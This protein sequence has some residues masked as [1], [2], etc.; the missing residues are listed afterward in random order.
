MLA[1]VLILVFLVWVVVPLF[2]RA[3]ITE[4]GTEP[5]ASVPAAPVLLATGVDEY[6]VMSWGLFGDGTL[7]VWRFDTGELVETLRP[8]GGEELTAL[9]VANSDGRYAVGFAD[10]KVR[11]AHFTFSSAFATAAELGEVAQRLDARGRALV[12]RTVVERT[13]EGEFRVQELRPVIGEP[14]E[15]GATNAITS[16]DASTANGVTRVLVCERG[17]RFHLAT[18]EKRENPFTGETISSASSIALPWTGRSDGAEPRNVLVSGVGDRLFVVWRDG[19]ARRYDARDVDRITLAEELDFVDGAGELTSLSFLIGRTTI[20]VGDS[21]GRLRAWFGV[22]PASATAVDGV[23][24]VLAHELVD[25]GGAR[26]TSVASSSRGRAIVAGFADGAVRVY[27]VT[28]QKELFT[29]RLDPPTPVVAVVFAPKDDGFAA[30]TNERSSRWTADLGHPEATVPALFGRVWYEGYEHPEHVWQS[31]SGTDDFEPKLGL[32]PLVFGTL[33]ATLYSLLFG[34]PLALLAA[35]YT[36]EFLDKRLKVPLKSFVELMASLPSVVLGFIAAIILAPFV[37][38][39]VPSV[40]A[41]FLTI[42]LSLLLG[43][44]LWQLLPPQLYVRWAGAPRFAAMFV[45]LPV[46]VLMAVVAGPAFER[47]F[48]GGDLLGWLDGQHGNG[49]GGWMLLLLPACALVFAFGSARLL[50]PFLRRASLTWSRGRA[51]SFDLARF[52]LS[53]VGV[54]ALAW[55]GALA[56]DGV[57]LDSRGGVLDTYE[58]R[59]ALIVGFIMGFAIIPIIYT[60][61]EDALSSVPSHLRLASLGAGATPWQTAVRIV[62][63]TAMSGLFSAVMIGLG[64][65]VGETMIVLMATGNTAVM[66]WN[67]FDG[68]RTL[69]ANIAV[70]LPEAVKDSTHYRT[71]FLAGLCLFAMTFVANTAAE[72]VRQRFRKRAYQL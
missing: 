33:K 26:A 64:R 50:S 45:A 6:Q 27:H 57:G 68:F 3:R 8:F 32:V 48:F 23:E 15:I 46:G 42:P 9:S 66:S 11:L 18:I 61:A 65:A 53:A 43:A 35:I 58:Q 20:V 39:V 4:H 41:A 30:W 36:S 17:S 52:G 34:V 72:L 12:G 60:L 63:P 56:L 28:S 55:L 59:N 16:V 71:L 49:V 1:V 31:S 24:Y 13:G 10:G 25:E 29:E 22:R 38:D 70:E 5:L 44:H 67:V 54:F 62:V 51:A 14:L 37:Q 21:R 7:A 69:S 2:K 40:L 19:M 47:W